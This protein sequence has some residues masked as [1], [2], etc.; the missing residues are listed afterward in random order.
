[1]IIY[2]FVGKEIEMCTTVRKTFTF[3]LKT[4]YNKISFSSYNN[5]INNLYI[6]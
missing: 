5:K 2:K 3:T 6:V 4:E 1:M